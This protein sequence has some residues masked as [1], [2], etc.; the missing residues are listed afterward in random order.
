M[1]LYFLH[2]YNSTGWSRDEE[3]LD[4]PD[5]DAARAQAVEGIRSILS[6]EVE[7]GKIDFAG[8]I[9]IADESGRVLATVTYHDAVDL[10]D[11]KGG[12]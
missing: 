10:R 3:G 9:E 5:L 11:E 2:V 6:D 4:L 7:H 12:E 1:P 8:K